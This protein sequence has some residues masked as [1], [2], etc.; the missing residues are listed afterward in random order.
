M[1]NTVPPN[2]GSE[3]STALFSPARSNLT[4]W[5]PTYY[6]LLVKP[7]H[8]LILTFSRVGRLFGTS[9]PN[10]LSGAVTFTSSRV[11]YHVTTAHIA[12][13]SA[14]F[15]AC[16][17]STCMCK[18]EVVYRR[19]SILQTKVHYS[20]KTRNMHITSFTLQCLLHKPFGPSTTGTIVGQ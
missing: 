12:R 8:S 18:R 19:S 1:N 15:A 17:R 6:T 9:R 11:P 13:A 5:I 2:M 3:L 10:T 7:I 14:T 4:Y 20:Y 16:V